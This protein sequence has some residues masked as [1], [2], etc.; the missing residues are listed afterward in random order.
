MVQPNQLSIKHITLSAD[1]AQLLIQI[2]PFDSAVSAQNIVQLLQ[3]PTL[4][5]FKLNIEG[6]KQAVNAFRNQITAPPGALKAPEIIIANKVDAHLNIVIANDKLSAYAEITTSYGG[7]TITLQQIK[8]KCDELGVKFGLLPRSM[9]AL[10]NTA[11]KAAPGKTYKV[12]IAFGTPPIDG[13]NAYFKTLVDTDNHRQL[14]PQLLP[15]GR[16]DMRNLGTLIT[17]PAGSPLMQKIPAKEGKQGKNILAEIIPQKAAIDHQFKLGS[18]VEINPNNPLQLISTKHGI[19]L[20]DGKF[21][22]INDVLLIQNVD[23]KTGNIDYNGCIVIAGDVND[24]MEVKAS[25]DITVMGLIQSATIICGGDLT[26]NKAIIGR[27]T[28]IDTQFSCDIV[29]KGNLHGSMAQY[30]RIDVAKDI[31]M[32]TQLMHCSTTCKGAIRVHNEALTKGTIIGG[33]TSADGYITT[34]VVGT[35]GGNQTIINLIGNYDQLQLDKETCIQ[36]LLENSTTLQQ[37]KQTE[38]R[39]S[40]MI[41]G[42][43]R[44]Q[45]MKQLRLS[46]AAC[47]EQGD[48]IQKNLSAAKENLDVYFSTTRFSVSKRLYS[49]CSVSIANKM[50]KSQLEHGPSVVAIEG[51]KIQLLAYSKDVKLS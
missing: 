21:I 36:Q 38:S 26:V 20:N 13:Q 42:K 39:L 46:K 8:T 3:H 30:S 27:Q 6:I 10:V 15:D 4:P 16:V 14:I 31:L 41:V 19:P 12:N 44:A 49:D 33:V 5:A 23:V 22:K 47:R 17:L 37:L 24:G 28:H 50:W 51:D 7:Q 43:E 9:L 45:I 34:A 35:D 1:K 29:C 2:E 40:S 48:L 18:H 25:G 32:T 11:N